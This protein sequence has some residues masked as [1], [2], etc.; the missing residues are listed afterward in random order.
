M[1]ATALNFMAAAAILIAVPSQA[2]WQKATTRHFTFYA[3]DTPEHAR[4][5]AIKLERFDKVSRLVGRMGDPQPTSGNRVTVFEV[6]NISSVQKL[7]GASGSGIAGFYR[8]TAEGTIAVVPRNASYSG[9]SM[10]ADTIFFHEYTHHLMLQDSSRAYPLWLSEGDAEMMSTVDFLANGSIL[11][12]KSADHRFND[13]LYGP[14]MPAKFMMAD[15][16]K[17]SDEDRAAVYGR[18]WLMTHYLTFSRQRSG[19]LEKYMAAI[20]SGQPSL[21][22]ARAAFGPLDGLDLDAD[23]YLRQHFLPSI[24][25][26][27]DKSGAPDVSV[28]TLSPAESAAM[29]WRLQSKVGVDTNKARDVLD[30]LRPIA[31]ANPGSELIQNALA[32][33]ELDGGDPALA[34]AA[35]DR[36]IIANPAS[37]EAMVFKGRALETLAKSGKKPATA[38]AEARKLFI[39]ANKKDPENALPLREFYVSYEEEN[40]AP[41]ANAV[42]ALHYAAALVPQDSDLRMRSVVQY[43]H[44]KQGKEA[45]AELTPI[46]YS[47]HSGATGVT[48]RAMIAKLD[49]GDPAGALAIY[50]SDAKKA[51]AEA[52]KRKKG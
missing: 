44:D 3:D 17:W 37:I 7:L 19:Q 40:L 14:K 39:A 45:R 34:E 10:G 51:K 8:Q 6:P 42:S 32:E 4:A 29:P 13:L 27:T 52:D 9:Y 1:R 43:L 49:A 20:D 31:A 38:F 46:A 36:A 35:A 21:A 2:A 28:A 24:T 18:G 11:V 33:A 30:H 15:S 5:A 16:S 48:G 50:E 47:P 25:I 22:A 12:G 23:N 41:T 26:A